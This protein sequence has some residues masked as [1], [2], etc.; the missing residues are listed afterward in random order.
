MFS[1]RCYFFRSVGSRRYG[2]TP[3]RCER[4]YTPN[5]RRRHD[6]L[7]AETPPRECAR[8]AKEE[9]RRGN[10]RKKYAERDISYDI[11][12]VYCV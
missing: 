12:V 4:L 3:P 2:T 10:D 5:A 11:V 6:R 1:A 8:G 7:V 9:W